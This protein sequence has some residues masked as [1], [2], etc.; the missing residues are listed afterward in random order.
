MVAATTILPLIHITG[1]HNTVIRK[2][3][4]KSTEKLYYYKN[5]FIY[6][7]IYH[8]YLVFCNRNLSP[9]PAKI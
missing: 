6:S 2:S 9:V 7:K 8:A 5:P 1:S 3:I 4:G